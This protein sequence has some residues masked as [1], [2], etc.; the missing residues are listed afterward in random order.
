MDNSSTIL[1]TR[2]LQLVKTN[3]LH[4]R[5]HIS[6]Q[7]LPVP[8]EYLPVVL[9]SDGNKV[10]LVGGEELRQKEEEER[11]HRPQMTNTRSK[12]SKG[13]KDTTEHQSMQLTTLY[14]GTL[15]M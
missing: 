8:D 9:V 14:S 6:E 10:L 4:V 2:I 1:E 11:I 12:G 5:V 15:L 7:Y 3:Q 13:Y